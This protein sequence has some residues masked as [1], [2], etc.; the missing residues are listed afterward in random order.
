MKTYFSLTLCSLLFFIHLYEFLV[1]KLLLK[2]KK[3][4]WKCIGNPECLKSF[5]YGH[6]LKAH[7]AACETAQKILKHEAAIKKL[8][9]SIGIDYPG[10]TGIKGNRH[11]PTFT[12]LDQRLKIDNCSDRFKYTPLEDRY[13]K[14]SSSSSS[15]PIKSRRIL[16]AVSSNVLD[17]AQVR[18]IMEHPE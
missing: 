1:K 2:K 15:A 14:S 9:F 4:K 12:S 17:S 7:V 3:M 10:I 11:F 18:R 6:A 8:E 16:K 13:A 5:E